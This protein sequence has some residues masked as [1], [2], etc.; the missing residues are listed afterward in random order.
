M[1]PLSQPEGLF[2]QAVYQSLIKFGLISPEK[3]STHPITSVEL[4]DLTSSTEK[5]GMPKG[6]G[7][8]IKGIYE[9]LISHEYI[10][11]KDYDLACFTNI[12][13][14]NAPIKQI[15][16][17]GD[18]NV[19]VTI[20]KKLRASPLEVLPSV[21]D[22]HKQLAGLFRNRHNKPLKPESIR[23]LFHR[24][25]KTEEGIDLVNKVMKSV[26]EIIKRDGLRNYRDDD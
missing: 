6:G 21:S 23:Q 16:I 19:I 15:K 2:E 17:K 14:G 8:T 9:L 7:E 20:I 24:N 11:Q 12:F 22:P 13:I 3:S 18:V 5:L 26:E 10:I 4:S 25:I 1:E